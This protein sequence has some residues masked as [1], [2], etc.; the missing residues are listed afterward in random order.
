MKAAGQ[1][2]FQELKLRFCF[3][4]LECCVVVDEARRTGAKLIGIRLRA[5]MNMMLYIRA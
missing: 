5:G 1:K 4:R 3:S 2:N